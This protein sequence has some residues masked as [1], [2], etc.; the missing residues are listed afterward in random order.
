[1]FGFLDS[2][3]KAST[4]EALFVNFK[5]FE[6]IDAKSSCQTSAFIQQALHTTPLIRGTIKCS[7]FICEES[8]C[9]QQNYYWKRQSA[10]PCR[11]GLQT[12]VFYFSALPVFSVLPIEYLHPLEQASIGVE[13]SNGFLYLL[14]CSCYKQYQ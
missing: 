11:N 7:T 8:H 6:K 4:K 14:F 13:E 1:L 2:K 3:E 12:L 5:I 9:L 10:A